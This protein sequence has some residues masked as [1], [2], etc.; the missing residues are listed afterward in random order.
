MTGEQSRSLKIGD[1][2]CWQVA[3]GRPSPVLLVWNYWREISLVSDRMLGPPQKLA[4][5]EMAASAAPARW[6]RFH[7]QRQS[8]LN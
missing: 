5:E 2:L 6:G 8:V 3:A 1:R 4:S 7:C